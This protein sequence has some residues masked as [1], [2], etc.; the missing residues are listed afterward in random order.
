MSYNK[1]NLNNLKYQNYKLENFDFRKLATSIKGAID[2]NDGLIGD[3]EAQVNKVYELERKF[4]NDITK[5]SECSKVYDKF[6]KYINEEL[7]NILSSQSFFREKNDNFKKGISKSIK[8]K[9]TKSL[10]KFD[11]NYQLI[12]FIKENWSGEL[13]KRS[14]KYYKDLTNARN[15]LIENNLP[16]AINRAKIFYNSTPKG[17]MTLLDFIDICVSGLV[18]GIDKYTGKYTKI[19]RSVCIGRMVGFMIAEYSKTFITMYPSDK[20]ILYR[21]NSLRN[22]LKIES[23]EDLTNAVNESFEKDQEEGRKVPKLPIS[24]IKISTLLNSCDYTSAS[25]IIS[26]N[27]DSLDYGLTIYD[28]TPSSDN[29][30]EETI[31]K[32]AMKKLTKAYKD[33]DMMETKVIRLKGVDV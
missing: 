11:I 3:Q 24:Q 14:Q 21:A 9:D 2:K 29:I 22:K 6:I 7:G 32:D 27:E 17:R 18:V 26:S 23:V 25:S 4:Q 5:Y 33:L 31:K 30:E 13:P 8:N 10:M 1:G 19:W 28:L 20:K 12:S 16:L 15:I